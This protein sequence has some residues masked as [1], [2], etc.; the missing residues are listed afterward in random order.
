[1]LDLL[2]IAKA[3]T[4]SRTRDASLC[5]GVRTAGRRSFQCAGLPDSGENGATTF[6]QPGDIVLV[7]KWPTNRYT[8]RPGA[9]PSDP[10]MAMGSCIGGRAWRCWCFPPCWW[11]CQRGAPLPDLYRATAL[12]IDHQDI[13]GSYVRSSVTSELRQSDDSSADHHRRDWALIQS[14]KLYPELVGRA[15]KSSSTDAGHQP[16]SGVSKRAV[17]TPPSRSR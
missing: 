2:A 9:A 1:V 13:S 10:E 5:S 14:L 4:N 7:S 3:S 16:G 8:G 11:H 6:V 17:A 12:L 15:L